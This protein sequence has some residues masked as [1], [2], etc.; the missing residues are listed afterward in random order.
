MLKKSFNSEPGFDHLQ[1]H[2]KKTLIQLTFIKS[3]IFSV[4]KFTDL[5]KEEIYNDRHPTF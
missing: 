3:D 5:F 2:A 1:L 4:V